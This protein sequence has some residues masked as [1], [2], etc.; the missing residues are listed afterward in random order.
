MNYSR[1]KIDPKDDWVQL[2]E[3]CRRTGESKY[4][5]YRRRSD[6]QWID[7]RECK[8]GRNKKIWIN[9]DAAKQWMLNVG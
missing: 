8:L 4:A 9:M 6:G 1:H 7:G 2:N 5:V 3:Y